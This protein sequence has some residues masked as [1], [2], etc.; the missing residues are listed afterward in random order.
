[1]PLIA[2]NRRNTYEYVLSGLVLDR[3]L[4]F[5]VKD[6]A[7]DVARKDSYQSVLSL[8]GVEKD[9]H[10]FKKGVDDPDPHSDERYIAVVPDHQNH[11]AEDKGHVQSVEHAVKSPEVRRR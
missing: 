1:M 8:T 9:E 2:G 6:H 7:D 10:E 4:G 3:F 5:E 11:H